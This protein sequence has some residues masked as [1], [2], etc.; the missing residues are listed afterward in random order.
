VSQQYIC[1]AGMLCGPT[2]RAE[3]CAMLAGTGAAGRSCTNQATAAGAA[4]QP[5]LLQRAYQAWPTLFLI[6]K[7]MKLVS[8]STW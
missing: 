2:T 4:D 5:L 6:E 3:M 7:L 8:T 1:M